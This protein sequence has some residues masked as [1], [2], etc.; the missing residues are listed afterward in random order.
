[1]RN[2]PAGFNGLEGEEEELYLFE[3][4]GEVE[5]EATS[6]EYAREEF[7]NMTIKEALENGLM[8]G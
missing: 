4:G 1:M 8:E 5:I 7:L 3:V 6:E 2:Y